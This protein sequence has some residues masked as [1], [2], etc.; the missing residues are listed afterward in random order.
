MKLKLKAPPKEAPAE[1]DARPRDGVSEA[2]FDLRRWLTEHRKGTIAT[3]LSLAALIMI[4]VSPISLGRV[5]V[6]GVLAGSVFALVALGVALVYKATGVLNFAQGELGTMPAFIVLMLMVG[7]DRQAEVNPATIGFGAMVSYAL[8][9]VVVGIVL[10]VG[11]NALV[12]QRLVDASPVISIVATTSVFF[13]LVGLQFAVFET[14]V[15]TFPRFLDG[16]PCLASQAGECVRPLT[17]FGTR[18]LWQA[19]V[20]VVVLL[21]VAVLLT[22]LFRTP[23]GIALLASAQEPF[24]ASLYGVSPRRMSTFAWAIAG[25]LGGLAGILGGGVFE[26]LFPGMMTRDFLVP[27]FTAA[28]LGGI[29]SMIGAVLGGLLLGIASALASAIVITYGLTGAVPGPPF[30]AAF[31]VLLVIMY[32]RPRGLL[33]KGA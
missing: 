6:E 11:I 30:V 23:V 8:L 17:L 14:R 31:V 33:G 22:L 13:L 1:G 9:A 21:I 29:T 16:A 3:L 27:A 15:R 26:Q 24:A 18:V 32:V 5:V 10:A 25:A 12:M 4:G 28:V 19:I 7:F 2:G 20:V